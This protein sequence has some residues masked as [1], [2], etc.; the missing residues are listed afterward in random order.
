MSHRGDAPYLSGNLLKKVGSNLRLYLERCGV[1]PEGAKIIIVV[2]DE[3]A[4]SS[5]ISG[6]LR[7]YDPKTMERTDAAP[8]D[9]EVLGLPIHVGVL[10]S[11]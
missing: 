4:R 8:A 5:V 2:P 10:E 6:L 7:D 3:I 1:D 11:A 9:V